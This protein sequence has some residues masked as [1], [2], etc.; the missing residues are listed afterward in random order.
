M[1]SVFSGV[2]DMNVGGVDVLHLFSGG[3]ADSD[4][5]SERHRYGTKLKW[6]ALRPLQ[7]KNIKDLKSSDDQESRSMWD[8]SFKVLEGIG[9]N[10]FGVHRNK[11]LNNHINGITSWLNNTDRTAERK[12]EMVAMRDAQYGIDTQKVDDDLLIKFIKNLLECARNNV[13]Y[14]CSETLYECPAWV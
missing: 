5:W 8:S 10:V 1:Q 14:V 12:A 7:A 11:R 9:A 6:L 3:S 13:R 2:S 4:T